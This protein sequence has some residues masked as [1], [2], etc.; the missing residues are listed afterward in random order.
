MMGVMEIDGHRAVIQFDPEIRMFRGEFTALNGGADFYADSVAGLEKEGR[1]SLG[2]FLDVCREKTI[3][4]MRNFSGKFMVRV[5]SELHARVTE[6]AAVR[7]VSIN[8][9]IQESVEEAVAVFGAEVR[10]HVVSD[11]EP[12]RAKKQHA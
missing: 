1:A 6:M 8:H 10:E 9:L 3:E 7:G 11:R 2:V 4:P 5:P 12:A